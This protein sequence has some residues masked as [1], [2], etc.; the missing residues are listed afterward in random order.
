MSTIIK[1][2]KQNGEHFVPITLAEAVVVNT[3]GM[4]GV[5]EITTLDKVLQKTIGATNA[6]ILQINQ[7]ISNLANSKQNKLTPG[8]GIEI[9]DDNKINVTLSQTLYQVVTSLP[10]PSVNVTNTI[11]IVPTTDQRE[12]N[13]CAEYICLYDSTNNKYYWEQFGTFKTD[14]GLSEY[15]TEIELIAYSVTAEDMTTSTAAGSKPI[16]VDYNIP[17]GLYDDA[18]I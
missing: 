14:V 12:T 6:N 17:E 18:V 15:V 1:R 2:L 9:T 5:A 13:K 3:V 8:Y 7:A 10:N 4:G 16:A 11:Y